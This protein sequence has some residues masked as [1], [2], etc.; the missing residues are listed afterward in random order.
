MGASGQI[1]GGGV[2]K[3][4]EAGNDNYLERREG[5]GQ[6]VVRADRVVAVFS[7]HG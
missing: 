1:D 4:R 7:R 6:P 5:R 3:H 2:G